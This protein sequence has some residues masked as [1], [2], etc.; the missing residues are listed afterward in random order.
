ML[1]VLTITLWSLTK[2]L[3]ANLRAA[4]GFDIAFIN[5]ASAAALTLLALFLIGSALV[6]VRGQ[7]TASLVPQ[8]D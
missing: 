3:I 1:F 8:A 7:R 5:A 6:K 2:L 4:H